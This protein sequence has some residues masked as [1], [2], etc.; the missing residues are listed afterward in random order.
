MLRVRDCLSCMSLC[1]WTFNAHPCWSFPQGSWP[2]FYNRASFCFLESGQGL[3]PRVCFWDDYRSQPWVRAQA[4]HLEKLPY[5]LSYTSLTR[6]VFGSQ[7][8][9]LWEPIVCPLH[10]HSASCTPP[11][12]LIASSSIPSPSNITSHCQTSG[13]SRVEFLSGAIDHIDW[14]R[15]NVF[16]PVQKGKNNRNK[17]SEMKFQFIHA[18]STLLLRLPSR[19]Q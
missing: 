14:S 12:P 9:G 11:P 5:G 10:P 13:R 3:V 8:P 1:P 17:L 2:I 18:L 4:P 15:R 6:E 7:D 16:L 19:D